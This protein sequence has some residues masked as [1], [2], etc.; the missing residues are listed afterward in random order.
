MVPTCK[1]RFKVLLPETM[2]DFFLFPNQFFLQSVQKHT[3]REIYTRL[4]IQVIKTSWC[5][6]SILRPKRD[7]SW[8]KWPFQLE[9]V[10]LSC[11]WRRA[12][13][14]INKIV[15]IFHSFLPYYDKMRTDA[16]N[17]SNHESTYVLSLPHILLFW[18]FLF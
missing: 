17:Y 7:I 13:K 8:L 18:T 5:L 3:Y 15:R 12:R 4:P 2:M 1:V 14:I 11:I 9:K 10:G 16:G 6:G